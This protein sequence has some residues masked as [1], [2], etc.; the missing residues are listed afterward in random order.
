MSY[1]A[2]SNKLKSH[3]ERKKKVYFLQL[4]LLGIKYFCGL[5]QLTVKRF[6]VHGGTIPQTFSFNTALDEK[7]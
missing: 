4:L 2:D 5:R 6:K 7:L 1:I 3:F